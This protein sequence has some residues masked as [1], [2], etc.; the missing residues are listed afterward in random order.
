VTSF[1]TSFG[2]V[3]TGYQGRVN[4]RVMDRKESPALRGVICG[5]GGIMRAFGSVKDSSATDH[6]GK[7]AGFVAASST[8]IKVLNASSTFPLLGTRWTI[9]GA[10]Q[11]TTTAAD[12]YVFDRVLTISGSPYHAPALVVTTSNT[13]SLKW[14]NSAGV[15][16]SIDSVL[17]VTD[18]ETYFFIA[19]RLD[20]ALALYVGQI[21]TSPT[22]W[23]SGTGLGATDVPADAGSHA[24]V[25]GA[26]GTNA[27]PNSD[28]FNGFIDGITILELAVE[29]FDMPYVEWA[30]PRMKRCCLHLPLEI[31]AGSEFVDM[32]R[33][34]YTITHH[35]SVTHEDTALMASPTLVN[36]V[37]EVVKP[38]A[39]Q[40][41]VTIA[42]GKFYANRAYV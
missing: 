39:G 38:D 4:D 21:G 15:D 2:P 30:Q 33:N 19:R 13:L 27:T 35:A 26:N 16:K 32:S 5:E 25:V 20:D 18:T 7:S 3:F 1:R 41:I 14:T 34:T 29:E 42:D 31:A 23:A 8:Y 24:F 36:F 11:A 6:A 17:T 12:S 10:F 40:R 37:G 28:H 9:M 22:L